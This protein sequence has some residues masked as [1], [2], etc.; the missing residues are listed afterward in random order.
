MQTSTNRRATEGAC[1]A[2]TERIAAL[3][4]RGMIQGVLAGA[5]GTAVGAI[6]LSRRESVAPEAVEPH[7]REAASQSTTSRNGSEAES[8]VPAFRELAEEEF[9]V[10]ARRI[11]ERHRRQTA[12]T[13]AEL[14]RKYEHPVFGRVRVW[15]LVE[16]LALCIDPTD[17]DL[18]GGSQWLHVQQALAAMEM[19]HVTDENFFLIA[20]LHDLGKLFLQTGEV[21]EN[22]VCGAAPLGSYPAGIGLDQVVYQFGHGELIYSRIKDHVPE[23]VAWTARYHTIDLA[24]AGPV[25]NERDQRLAAE[26]LSPFREFDAGFKSPQWLPKIDMARYR[27]LIERTFPEP[28]LF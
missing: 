13:V 17:T 7:S 22:V 24:V 12:A 20:I 23:P 21:P 15:D 27:E 14:K 8:R 18:F 26:Y 19:Q 25:M 2:G 3:T 16:K 9:R 6:A 28:I 5:A 1:V 4:R 11:H 10:E